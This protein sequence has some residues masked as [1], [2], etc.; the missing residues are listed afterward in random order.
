MNAQNTN[1]NATLTDEM[2]DAATGGVKPTC[3]LETARVASAEPTLLSE[4]AALTSVEVGSSQGAMDNAQLAY[5][6]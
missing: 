4:A 3:L 6:L 2:L 1:V 5:F